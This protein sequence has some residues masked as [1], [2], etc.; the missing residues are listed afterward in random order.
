MSS[1]VEPTNAL[2]ICVSGEQQLTLD[3]AAS[4]KHQIERQL[5]HA[6]SITYWAPLKSFKR[7]IAIF[8]TNEHA[9]IARQA[10]EAQTDHQAKYRAYFTSDLLPDDSKSGAL[11]LPDAGKLWLISPPASP[12]VGWESIREEHPNKETI[13]ESSRLKEAL[14][15]MLLEGS[16]SADV[17]N[18][19]DES[20]KVCQNSADKGDT[21][22]LDTNCNLSPKGIRR[23][24]LLESPIEGSRDDTSSPITRTPSIVLEW[25]D[26]GHVSE[27]VPVAPPLC[28]HKMTIRTERP[29]VYH[30][31]NHSHVS[32]A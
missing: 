22:K 16:K 19:H 1:T 25:D 11:E 21:L 17:E 7:I 8:D 27:A 32:A 28:G 12:P 13:F 29:P 15:R 23:Y 4:I 18:Y 5:E 10:V 24:T 20:S 2:I 26:D 31:K 6:S 3:V 9:I 30:A 14:E